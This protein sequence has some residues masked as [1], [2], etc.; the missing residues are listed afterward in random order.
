MTHLRG[1]KG[2]NELDYTCFYDRVGKA[3]GWDFSKL[4]VTSEGVLWDYHEEIK[5]KSHQSHI[6]LD[7]GTGGG[8]KVLKMASSFLFL[9][10]ID[11]SSSMIK[12]AKMNLNKSHISNV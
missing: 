12:T 8:E 7:I 6:L 4:T 10:G 9:V 1:G 2:L 5:K 3:N 11:L